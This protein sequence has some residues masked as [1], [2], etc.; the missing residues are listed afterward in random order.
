MNHEM[1]EHHEKILHSQECFRIQG[2]IYEVYRELGAG[3]LESVYQE[4]LE[5]EFISC[6]IPFVSQKELAITYRGQKLNQGFRADFIC[7]DAVLLEIK[8]VRE[9]APEHRAQILNYLKAT[10]LKVGLL[11]NFGSHPKATIQRFV[12]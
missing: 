6:G 2:A 3:F 9:F 1:H 8:A 5:R 4:S 10:G 7:F 12:N 11:V